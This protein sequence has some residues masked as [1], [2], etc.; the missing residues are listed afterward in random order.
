MKKSILAFLLLILTVFQAISQDKK[1][2]QE[3]A[4][5]PNG[6]PIIT[7]FA[8]VHTLINNGTAETGFQLTRG[9]LGYEY[10]FSKN[11]SGKIVF[12]IGNI[13]NTKYQMISFVKFAMMT[14]KYENLSINFGLIPPI[15][16]TE[17]EKFWGHR[18][19]EK[20]YMDAYSFSPSA[21]LGVSATY[22]FNDIISANVAVFN[23]EG[24]KVQ[25][26]D[27]YFKTAVGVIINPIEKLTVSL[28]FDFMGQDSTQFTYGAF[29][30]YKEEKFIVGTEYNYQQNHFMSPGQNYYGP[31]AYGTYYFTKKISIYARYDKLNSNVTK[32]DDSTPW[33]YLQ[34]GQQ[35]IGGFE[36]APVKGIKISPNYRGWI[37]HD[38]SKSYTNAIFLNVEIKL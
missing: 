38:S 22:K 4:F 29:A 23:G 20:S 28:I 27:N 35:I 25:Q 10:N 12:D 9:Y 19:V 16:Y 21:D 33:N 7:V 37:P 2:T 14:Y 8:N 31:S 13:G 5:K 32:E 3:E 36:Y 18:Y 24:Y 15:E 6:K 34:D 26:M 11:F 30:G 17:Q 1:D